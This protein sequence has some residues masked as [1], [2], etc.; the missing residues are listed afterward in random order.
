[1]SAA[2]VRQRPLC[3]LARA[4][5]R[6]GEEEERGKIRRASAKPLPAGLGTRSRLS[7]R[8]PADR[9]IGGCRC[10]CRRGVNT[11]GCLGF[12]ETT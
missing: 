7:H 10:R 8:A 6:E 11:R 12:P 4:E 2:A 1:M 9:R 3:E 5:W